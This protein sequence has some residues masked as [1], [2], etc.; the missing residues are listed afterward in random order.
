M[1]TS[2]KTLLSFCLAFAFCT[3]VFGQETKTEQEYIQDLIA[4]KRAFNQ[5]NGYGFRIQLYNG[6]ETES[7]KIKSKF[8][9]EFPEIQTYLTYQ[10]PEWKIQIGLYRTRLEADRALLQYKKKFSGAIVVPIGK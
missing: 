7:K 10:S 3:V 2:Q 9:V 6:L 8:E 4:K 5:E 1:K